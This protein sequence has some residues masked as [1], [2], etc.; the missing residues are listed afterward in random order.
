MKAGFVAR[1]NGNNTPHRENVGVHGP[2][3]YDNF[4]PLRVSDT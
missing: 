4:S 2:P 3:K 1:E